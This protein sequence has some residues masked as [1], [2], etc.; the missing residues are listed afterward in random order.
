[1]PRSRPQPDEPDWRESALC[2]EVDPDLFFPEK[3]GT[4]GPAKRICRSCEVQDECLTHALANDLRYGIWGGK[5]DQER[6]K[7]L[8]RRAAA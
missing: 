8:K 4:T 2:R 7:L 1:M 5:S 6:Q 3:G